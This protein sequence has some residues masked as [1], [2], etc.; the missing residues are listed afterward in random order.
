[1]TR[2]S[3]PT[4]WS[5]DRKR[6]D[7]NRPSYGRSG[8]PTAFVKAERLL[9]QSERIAPATRMPWLGWLGDIRLSGDY[10]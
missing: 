9:F 3:K 7:G 2:A 5:R 6:P 4:G 8:A 10:Q 1:V